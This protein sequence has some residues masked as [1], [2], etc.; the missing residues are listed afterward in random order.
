MRSRQRDSVWSACD[1]LGLGT[2]FVGWPVRGVRR[3]FESSRKRCFRVR[4]RAESRPLRQRHIRL[5][6]EHDFL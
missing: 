1:K 5:F 4:N 2:A 3:L 6:V